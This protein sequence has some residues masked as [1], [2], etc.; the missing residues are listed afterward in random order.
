MTARPDS[1]LPAS[2]PETVAARVRANRPR[3]AAVS[4]VDTRRRC[5]ALLNSRVRRRPRPAT[6]RAD[7]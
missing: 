6:F 7:S 3:V 5:T 2:E 1:D 4:G